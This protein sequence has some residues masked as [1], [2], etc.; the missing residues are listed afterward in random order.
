[1]SVRIIID[2]TADIPDRIKEHVSVVPLRLRFAEEEYIDG[3]TIN[4]NEFYEK[5]IETDVLPQT[6]Q[7]TPYDFTQVYDEI[8][9]N[10]DSAI[11]LAL[12]SKLSGTYQS[13]CVAAEDYDNIVVIDT[14]NVAIGAGILVEYALNLIENGME[15]DELVAE[16][17]AKKN[18]IC[19]IA[20]LDTLEYLKL[21]GRISK[22]VAL[23]GGLLNIKPVIMIKDGQV[24]LIGKARGSKQGNNFLMNYV[25]ENGLDYNMPVLLGYTGLSDHLLQKYIVDSKELWEGKLDE[26]DIA[27]VCSVIGIHAGPGAIAVAF[28]S[29]E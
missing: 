10:G 12:S 21:G 4:K 13:A 16:L 19:L 8:T 25:K 24:E 6:S 11:V 18:K 22:T 15:F 3:V 29:E 27:Q 26:L 28:F 1:M 5:L 9:D 2:S 20:L 14:L 7:A 23:A 17:E